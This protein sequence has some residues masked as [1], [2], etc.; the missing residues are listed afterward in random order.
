MSETPLKDNEISPTTTENINQEIVINIDYVEIE[1]QRT[2]SYVFII[3]SAIY[4]PLMGLK[5]KDNF[6]VFGSCFFFNI[7]FFFILL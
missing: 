5:S 4:F 3:L 6:F 7:L 1:L 2:I